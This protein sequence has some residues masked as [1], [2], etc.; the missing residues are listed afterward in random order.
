MH[1]FDEECGEKVELKP[2]HGRIELVKIQALVADL[3]AIERRFGP[4]GGLVRRRFE[5]YS[6]GGGMAY[7]SVSKTDECITHEGSTPSHGTTRFSFSF[8]N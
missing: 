8:V 3:S 7:A 2:R 1:E 5:R 4:G 6:R